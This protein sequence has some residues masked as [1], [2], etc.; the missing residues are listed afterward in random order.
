M[1]IILRASH[2]RNEYKNMQKVTNTFQNKVYDRI[3]FSH[4]KKAFSIV[5]Y[6]NKYKYQSRPMFRENKETQKILLQ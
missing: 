5:K 3:Y 6:L 1:T 4:I 2:M